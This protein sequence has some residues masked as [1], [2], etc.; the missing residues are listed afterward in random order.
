MLFTGTIRRRHLPVLCMITLSLLCLCM[1]SYGEG[2]SLQELFPSDSASPSLEGL[3]PSTETNP[4][5]TVQFLD[6]DGRLLTSIMLPAG[7]PV[8]MPDFIPQAALG[9]S[10]SHWADVE[11]GGEAFAF[12]AGISSDILLQA[13]FIQNIM[14][15][16]EDFFVVNTPSLL[17]YNVVVAEEASSATVLAEHILDAS[18]VAQRRV[19][20]LIEAD[21]PLTFGQQVTL[22]GNLTG[23]DDAQISLQWQYQTETGWVDIPGGNTLRH[24][25]TLDAAN[26]G[27]NWRLQ[28]TVAS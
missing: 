22:C 23:Y 28:V 15:T 7:Q 4:L 14:Q 26:A 2:P 27:Y 1:V 19:D 6:G 12:E 21:F 3:S 24:S 10:F 9:F 20:V 8:H 5:Y 17:P 18:P 11:A 16:A 13:C 25:F